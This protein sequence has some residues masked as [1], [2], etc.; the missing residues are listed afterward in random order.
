MKKCRLLLLFFLGSAVAAHA[1]SVKGKLL[2]LVD[3]K[4]LSGA[5]LQLVSVKDSLSRFNTVADSRGVF[6]FTGIPK[7][8]FSLRVSFVGYENYRQFVVVTDSLPDTDLGTVFIPKTSKEI[9]GVTVVSRTPPVQQKG[10][11]AQY[12]A[13]QY[14]VNPD[15]TTE[16]LI[17]KMP[18]ITV[19]KDG[20]VT[21]QGE[22]VR[23]VTIDGREFFGDDATAAL[24]NLPSEIVDKI[25]VFDRLSDQAQFTGIDDGNAVKA[26]NVVTKSGIKN[27]QFG[28]IYAGVGTDERYSAGGNVSFFKENRRISI[29][30]NFNNINQQNFASQDLLGVTSSGNS[31]RG[32]GNFGGGGNRGGGN[33]GGGFGGGENFTVGQQSGI[34]KTNAIG[35]NFSDKW[36]KKMDIQGSYFFNNSNNDNERIVKSQSLITDGIQYTNQNSF[37]QSRNN[38]HRVNL[39]LEYRIDSSN[40]IIISPSL[41]FQD[42]RSVSRS[43][44]KRYTDVD[45]L[46]NSEDNTISDRNGYNIRNN[47]LYRHSFPKRG[48]TFSINLNTTFNKNAGENFVMSRYRF[49]DES[50]VPSDSLQDQNIINP[51]EGHSISGN[52]NYT[53]PLSQKSQLQFNYSPSYSNNKANQQTYSFDPVGLKYSQFIDSLS[54]KFDNTTTTQNGGIT[55]RFSASR[56]DQFSVGVNFQY[57]RLE[58]DREFPSVTQVNQTF[59]NILPNLQWRKKI[60][61][62]SS[63]RFFYRA[64]TNFPSVTQ[65][66][67]VV[68]LSNPLRISSGNPNLKQSYTHFLSGR[69]MF[70]NTQKGQSFFANIF[71]QTA[72]DYISNAVYSPVNG[73]SVILNNIEL[74]RGSQYTTPV[75]LDGYKSL[76]SFFTYSMPVKFIKSNINLSTGFSYSRLPGLSNDV[77]TITNNYIYNAGVVIASNVSE[78]IDF[79]VFYNVNLNNAKSATIQESKQIN[80][81]TGAQL[82]LL[83]KKGWFLMN[84]VSFQRYTGDGIPAT[85]TLWNAGVGKKFLKNRVG[86]LKLTVFDLLKQNQSIYRT[87]SDNYIEDSES[88]VL[89]QY[90]MLTF[91]YSLKNFGKPANNFQRRENRDRM[92][93]Y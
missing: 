91:S 25:Q 67:D 63:I 39:R 54:N 66:Q 71:V 36:G 68:N 76:R 56:D 22:Q 51:T 35:I 58:S 12:N 75:N 8:S 33:R 17:K 77:Q 88:K 62:R 27:G 31:G 29:V 1:Q 34:S 20:T 79:N 37:S 74:K 83:T 3:N 21:A 32:G 41:N 6:E 82:N 50:G 13:S 2:D 59:S 15:A 81:N 5:T 87:V 46:S 86:E 30:G 7:D 26:I 49:Y 84:D 80:Q 18:G 92:P 61:A 64:N 43:I 10:D 52:L 14:K 11:T 57:S 4:P 89:Q 55:Y 28:R 65:L 23:K 47:I 90:F 24:R 42:N 60:S 70:T 16:D 53:E 9:G 40:S 85:Y 72:S 69:Y 78:Y 48:R 73:D 44:T 19:D 93:G 45:S 38:N